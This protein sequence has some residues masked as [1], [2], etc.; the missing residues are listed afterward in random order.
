MSG[1]R[2]KV[3][4]ERRKELDAS[5]IAFVYWRLGKLAVEEKRRRQAEDKARRGGVHSNGD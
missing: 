2:I 4:G 1:K 3:R 5:A